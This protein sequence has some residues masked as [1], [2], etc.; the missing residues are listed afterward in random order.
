M[1]TKEPR[2]NARLH[3]ESALHVIM[4]SIGSDV[5]YNLETKDVTSKGFFIESKQPGRFPFTASSIV[6]VWLEI[7][8]GTAIFFNGKISRVIFPEEAETLDEE[9]GIAIRVIQIE[10]E[11]EK[12]LAE[13]LNKKLDQMEHL[14]DSAENSDSPRN[15]A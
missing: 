2:R 12:R 6:E 1:S 13:F 10:P 3:L 14:E 7:D 9:P 11:E 8:A 15:V 4:G 5:R